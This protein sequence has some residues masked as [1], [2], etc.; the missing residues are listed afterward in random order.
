MR[1]GHHLK[2]MGGRNRP[3]R[4]ASILSVLWPLLAL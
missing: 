2:K 3:D 1:H 4:L